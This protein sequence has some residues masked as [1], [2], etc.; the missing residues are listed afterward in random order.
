MGDGGQQHE[1]PQSQQHAPI[2]QQTTEDQMAI[3][4]S[5]SARMAIIASIA[6]PVVFYNIIY[7]K[8]SGIAGNSTFTTNCPLKKSYV[9]THKN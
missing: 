2:V 9:N 3:M 6:S 8:K 7:C 5:M 1:P 4:H